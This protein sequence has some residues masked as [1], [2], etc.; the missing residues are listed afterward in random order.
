MNEIKGDI[1]DFEKISQLL[2]RFLHL[3]AITCCSMTTVSM[4]LEKGNISE[5]AGIDLEKVVL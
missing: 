3:K 1:M 2:R 4:K 5:S